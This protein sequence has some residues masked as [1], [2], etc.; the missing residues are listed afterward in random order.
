[1]SIQWASKDRSYHLIDRLETEVDIRHA[2]FSD[3]A[4]AASSEGR[5]MKISKHP[6]IK[7]FSDLAHHIFT[8]TG[9]PLTAEY[10]A[11]DHSERRDRFAK[12]LG[13]Y[14]NGQVTFFY[15]II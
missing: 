14:I 10:L 6:H 9:D 12:S 1:M 8:N 3:S 15:S 7:H 4:T 11:A 5:E 13:N 2:L